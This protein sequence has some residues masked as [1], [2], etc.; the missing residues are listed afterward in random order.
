MRI[1]NVLLEYNPKIIFFII[2]L[3]Y[4]DTKIYY[5]L[6]NPINYSLK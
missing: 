5:I 6:R 1:W 4:L 2:P 3:L